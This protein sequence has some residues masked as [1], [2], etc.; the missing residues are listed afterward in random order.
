MLAIRRERYAKAKARIRAVV[1][2]MVLLASISLGVANIK[3]AEPRTWMNPG[4]IEVSTASH[5]DMVRGCDERPVPAVVSGTDKNF[6]KNKKTHDYK[7]CITEGKDVSLAVFTGGNGNRRWAIKARSDKYFRVIVGASENE[8]LQLMP[9]T[10]RLVY[11]SYTGNYT[12]ATI[13]TIEN[14]LTDLI[15]ESLDGSGYVDHYVLSDTKAKKWLE[16]DY[17]GRVVSLPAYSTAFSPN[18]RYMIAWISYKGYVKIDFSTG[19]VTEIGRF[20]GAWYGGS[21]YNPVAA[22]ISSDG[23]YAFIHDGPTVVDTADC[24][25]EVTREIINS[26]T[27]F[28]GQAIECKRVQMYD[29]VVDYVGYN[30]YGSYYRWNYDESALEF[31]VQPFPN[32][33]FQFERKKVS[34]RLNQ[35][36]GTELDYLALGDSFSSGEGDT[37]VAGD[38]K[39]Y[40]PNTDVRGDLSKGIPTEKC[41]VSIRSYPYLIAKKMN[42]DVR[43]RFNSVA[44]SGAVVASDYLQLN[45]KEAYTGQSDRLKAYTDTELNNFKEIA[46]AN[47]IPGRIEQ[48]AFVRKYKPTTVTITGSGND[49]GFGDILRACVS[50]LDMS[51][52]C[53]YASGLSETSILG[54]E[55]KSQYWKLR[56]LYRRIHLSSPQTKIFVIGY[57]KF[58]SDIPAACGL[59]VGLNWT[60]RQVFHQAVVYL[61]DVIR[62]AATAE[63]V[64]YVDISDALEQGVDHRLCGSSDNYVN[65]VNLECDDRDF[66]KFLARSDECQE[67]FHPNANGHNAMANKILSVVHGGILTYNYCSDSRVVCPRDS[68]LPDAPSVFKDASKVD[69]NANYEPSYDTTLAGS[70]TLQKYNKDKGMLRVNKANLRPNSTVYAFI[71][72]TPTPVGTYTVDFN[73]I[74]SIVADVPLSLKAGYHTLHLQA[75]SHSGESV[76][77]WQI[78]RVLGK[79]GDIDEDGIDDSDDRCMFMQQLDSDMDRDGIDDG[80]DASISKSTSKNSQTFNS[81]HNGQALQRQSQTIG[82]PAT[83][84]FVAGDPSLS[85][86]SGLDATVVLN[87]HNKLISILFVAVGCGIVLTVIL[88]LKRGINNDKKER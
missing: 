45:N 65:G 23:R 85:G 60:E 71:A 19:K 18:G 7:G 28:N 72:S 53:S 79:E 1:F 41:H 11:M 5:E 24:G 73:G 52:T 17:E 63:G 54:Y 21:I 6:Y 61:N 10:N 25:R 29:R 68:S 80:C 55:I 81:G 47:F 87:G 84:Q 57:P 15:P 22:A 32:S 67:S 48:E 31:F 75:E 36:T 4:S 49:V 38:S 39:Y 42:I 2:F 51:D 64:M 27:L 59:S 86:G 66:V 34:I 12:Y 44:C 20:P 13:T 74:V 69:F 62:A 30:G 3:A 33:A 14:A 83:Y 35:E 58:I 76:D 82:A 26:G 56:D 16:Y 8:R 50:P 37:D 40:R 77:F 88:I 78:V 43:N 70:T 46:I 9:G